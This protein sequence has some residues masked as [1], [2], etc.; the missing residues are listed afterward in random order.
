MKDLQPGKTS[1][2]WKRPY[3]YNTI[4]AYYLLISLAIAFSLTVVNLEILNIGIDGVLVSV[5]HLPTL[6]L[7]TSFAIGLFILSVSSLIGAIAL[8]KNKKFGIYVSFFALF[9]TFMQY[10]FDY[11]FAATTIDDFLFSSKN[12]VAWIVGLAFLIL[13]TAVMYVLLVLGWKRV[14]WIKKP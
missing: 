9:A 10:F 7:L 13:P 3:L 1:S 6:I 14:Q 4:V 12:E 8:L 2:R 5:L 11:A